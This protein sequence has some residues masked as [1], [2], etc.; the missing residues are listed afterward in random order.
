MVSALSQRS[1]LK[2]LASLFP[3]EESEESEGADLFCFRSQESSAHALN[4]MV[5]TKGG[6]GFYTGLVMAPPECLS[7]KEMNPRK[8]LERASQIDPGEIVPIQIPMG[9][10]HLEGVIYYPS[11][12]DKSNQSRAVVYHNPNGVTVAG[13]FEKGF[14]EWTPAQ[15]LKLEKCPLIMY[16]YRGTGLSRDPVCFQPTYASVIEDGVQALRYAL[17]Q[18]DTVK[19]IGSSLGGGVATVSLNRY[20]EKKPSFQKR[21]SLW[22]HDSFSKIE[23]VILPQWSKTADF[24]GW[25]W[26]SEMDPAAAM[27]KL[28]RRKIPITILCH[29]LDPVIPTGAKMAEFVETLPPRNNLQMI[30]SPNA[31]HANLSREIVQLL[32]EF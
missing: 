20:L 28:I 9:A 4:W 12:W 15:I 26:K 31:G 25:I 29:R 8:T 30:Y 1:H 13:F 10:G 6:M 32:K 22:S 14:L 21:V 17:S 3:I 24:W 16:D 27:E 5:Q 23:R 7:S 2:S 19:V 18:F 11:N